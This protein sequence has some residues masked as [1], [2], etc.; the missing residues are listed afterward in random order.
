MTYKRSVFVLLSL[1]ALAAVDNCWALPSILL[2]TDR[3]VCYTVT[4]AAETKLLI[5]Y[6]A[7]DI[8][9][10][11]GQHGYHKSWIIVSNKLPTKASDPAS[12]FA[13]LQMNQK[14][15]RRTTETLKEKEGTVEHI[16]QLSGDVDVCVHSSLASKKNPMRFGMLV[17]R[18][19]Q[20]H[21]HM[22]EMM[23]K[24]MES[25]A[26]HHLTHMEVEMKHL[27]DTMKNILAEADF[28]KNKEAEFHHQTLHMDQAS[29]WWPILHLCV[30][31]VTGFTQANHVVR[32]FQKRHIV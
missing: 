29:T 27:E 13:N 19:V 25:V 22:A 18:E 2:T 14:D 3:P 15:L 11:P 8:P 17:D 6:E 7:P 1:I 24:E 21:Q 31:L 30:L 28:S 9:T 20:S 5:D 12:H 23:Q 26:D 16:V 10:E 32:F 4:A